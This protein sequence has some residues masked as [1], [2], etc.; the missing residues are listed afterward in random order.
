MKAKNK[1]ALVRAA[2]VFKPKNYAAVS[3]EDAGGFMGSS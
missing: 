1:A 2:F 3:S